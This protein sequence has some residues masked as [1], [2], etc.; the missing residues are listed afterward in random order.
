MGVLGGNRLGLDTHLALRSR[1]SPAILRRVETPLDF[2]SAE[3]L[4]MLRAKTA[5][6]GVS[7]ASGRERRERNVT[8]ER[9]RGKPESDALRALDQNPGQTPSPTRSAPPT[10]TSALVIENT[11]LLEVHR[12]PARHLQLQR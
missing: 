12:L 6:Q 9:L 10:S 11:G 2:D 5:G 4:W 1:N 8:Q 3:I 7:D